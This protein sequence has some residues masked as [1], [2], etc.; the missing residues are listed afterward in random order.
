[1][2]GYISILTMFLTAILLLTACDDTLTTPKL[3]GKWQLKTVEKNGMVT[4]V[5]TVWYN[6]Q[7][8]SVFS[9]QVYVPQEDTVLVILGMKQQTDHVLSIELDSETYNEYSDWNGIYR[10]FTIDKLGQKSLILRSEEE[11]LYTFKKF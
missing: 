9:M 6:F 3:V 1:M 5:D 10:T 7:S 2:K 11:Y 4:P 8:E